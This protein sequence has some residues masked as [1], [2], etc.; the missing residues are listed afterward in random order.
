MGESPHPRP[1]GRQ[2]RSEAVV[3]GT[4]SDLPAD[5]RI[6]WLTAVDDV[7]AECGRLMSVDDLTDFGSHC[8]RCYTELFGGTEDD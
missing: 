6:Y 1:P 5:Q 7:C 8:K 3:S 2:R 4:E